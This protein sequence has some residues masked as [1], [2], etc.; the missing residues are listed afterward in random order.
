MWLVTTRLSVFCSTS[1]ASTPRLNRSTRSHR[2]S[3]KMSWAMSIQMWLR[4]STTVVEQLANTA[5]LTLYTPGSCK[6]WLQ[7]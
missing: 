5:K 6:S 4:R 3:K 1:R 2:P 7:Q